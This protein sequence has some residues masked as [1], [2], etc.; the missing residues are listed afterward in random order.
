MLISKNSRNFSLGSDQNYG[1]IYFRIVC[2]L[3]IAYASTMIAMEMQGIEVID[4]LW[5]IFYIW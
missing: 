1:F 5:R 3:S 4:E 2:L